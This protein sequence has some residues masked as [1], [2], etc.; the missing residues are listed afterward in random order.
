MIRRLA[1]FTTLLAVL[2]AAAAE[3]FP[4]LPRAASSL[5]AA[6][7]GDWLYV[8]G[9]HCAKTHTYSTDA[10]LGAF[11]R[12]RL[13]APAAW[14]KL[15]TGPPA[16]GLALVAHQGKLYRIGGMQ[17][18]NKAGDKADNHSLASCACYDPALGKWAPLPDLPEPRSSHDA[19]VVGDKLIV[20]GGWNLQGAGKSNVW[21]TTALVL[22][23]GKSP[24]RWEALKQPFTR[25]ALAAAEHAGKVYVIGGIGEDAKTVLT[26]NVFDPAT[27]AWTTGPD[28]PSPRRNGFSPGA[29]STGGRLYVT[30]SDGRVLRLS[31]KHDAWEEAGELK[32]SRIVHRMTPGAGGAL[33]VVGGAAGGDNVALTEAIVPRVK[34]E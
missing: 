26:V 29:C 16:Q 10:V 14:E 1:F 28:L 33:I 24:L 17:P 13:S 4:D 34:G 19:V 3:P 22:D 21:H 25:R 31:A 11:Y 27:G 30:P 20:A 15:P 23:L 5:G 32:Q 18:R 9:G 8:Y 6:V 7:A 12:V 2:P